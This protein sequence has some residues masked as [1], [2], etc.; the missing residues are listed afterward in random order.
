MTLS[1]LI[2]AP[3]AMAALLLANCTGTRSAAV[4]T[5]ESSRVVFV[6]GIF[7][8]GR[9]FGPLVGKLEERGRDCLVPGLLPADAREGLEPLAEQLKTAIEE[10]WGDGEKFHIVAHSMGGLV[11]R[12][13][14]Q[15]LGGH[16]RCLSLT[17][18][19]TPHHGTRAA[20]LYPGTG[21]RQMRQG[22]AFLANLEGTEERLNGVSLHSFYT[23]MDLIILPFTSSKWDR[24]ENVV[25]PAPAHPLVMFSP[26]VVDHIVGVT[27]PATLDVAPNPPG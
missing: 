4:P 17:T 27:S 6:H 12:H 9:I 10:R 20:W 24:A 2:K 16:E 8:S 13:Y 1:R 3:F 11:S 5:T 23:P 22:S 15:H 7:Q 14:L 26:S 19:A 18:L 25:V 21:A